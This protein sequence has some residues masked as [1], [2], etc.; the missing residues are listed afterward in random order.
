LL[1]VGA[2]EKQL[3]VTRSIPGALRKEDMLKKDWRSAFVVVAMGLMEAGCGTEPGTMNGHDGNNSLVR[4][5]S[6]P[7]GTNCPAG[8]QLVAYGVDDDAN[9]I[10][11]DDPPEVDGSVYICNGA[12]GSAGSTGTQGPAGRDGSHGLNSLLLTSPLPSGDAHCPSGG[13]KVESGIDDNADGSLQS[14]EVD[15]SR[16]VCNGSAGYS[17]LILVTEATSGTSV[18]VDFSA[19]SASPGNVYTVPLATEVVVDFIPTDTLGSMTD[20]GSGWSRYFYDIN[21]Y[22]NSYVMRPSNNQTLYYTLRT[23]GGQELVWK[24]LQLLDDGNWPT[25]N[26]TFYAYKD[27]AQLASEVRAGD[28]P[29]A[30]AS[31]AVSYTFVNPA[32][33]DADMIVIAPRQSDERS[34]TPLAMDNLQVVHS[35][36][37][38]RGGKKL[39]VGLDD[40][41]GGGIARDGTLQAGE[42]DDTVL[43]CN[44]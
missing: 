44:P 17:S 23:R 16:Y 3:L 42:V 24:S 20:N 2:D 26:V 9:G 13:V 6:E 36:E 28:I 37:C 43:L 8:G 38:A 21:G 11:S 7:P 40:G 41:S 22:H 15:A 5:S 39:L 12:Q 29:W 1:P 32:F 10:L 30:G 34:A 14:G 19:S 31:G 25:A 27:G 35:R 33:A 18:T 4:V